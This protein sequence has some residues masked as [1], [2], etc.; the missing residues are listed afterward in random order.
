MEMCRVIRGLCSALAA[1]KPGVAATTVRL[2]YDVAV[3]MI[4]LL[5]AE[6]GFVNRSVDALILMIVPASLLMW[7]R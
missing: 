5:C 1:R 3:Y 4:P 6:C 2:E 7:R